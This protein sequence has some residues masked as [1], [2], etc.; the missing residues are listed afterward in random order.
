MADFLK[1]ERQIAIT[2]HDLTVAA[3]PIS[4]NGIQQFGQD[5]LVNLRLDF[6]LSI[7]PDRQNAMGFQHSFDLKMELLLIEPVNGGGHGYQIEGPV[8]KWCS[9]GGADAVTYLW[10]ENA[11]L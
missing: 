11:M 7:S 5:D 4:I 3:G 6:K 9:F 2:V 8:G 10:V 1:R